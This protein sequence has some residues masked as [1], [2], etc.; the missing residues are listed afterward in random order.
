MSCGLLCFV[1]HPGCERFQ[2]RRARKRQSPGQIAKSESRISFE[3]FRVKHAGDASKLSFKMG[4]RAQGWIVGV[5]ITERA[6]QEREQFRLVMIALG[7]NLYQLE[8]V[9]SRL[10]AK[11]ILPDA[12]ERIFEDDFRQSVQGRF[13]AGDDRNFGFEE[14]I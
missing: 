2:E 3:F 9:G 10:S 12:G 8:Q 1:F 13:A 6:T 4:D 14:E 7:A 11:I 5:E